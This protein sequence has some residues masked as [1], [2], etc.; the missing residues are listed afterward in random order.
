MSSPLRPGGGSTD[1]AVEIFYEALKNKAYTCYVGADT[2]LPMMYMHDAL[3]A[4]SQLM[5]AP[6]ASLSRSVYNVTAFS[7]S[8]RML[9]AIVA[10]HIP[11]FTMNCVPDFRDAIA[12]S[13][14]KSIDDSIAARDFG[15]KPEWGLEK[16]S[17]DMLEKVKA[18][19]G[20]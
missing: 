17:A 8:P 14:P 3:R 13:W 6:R 2:T 19:L 16:T 4:T 18:K 20:L 10:R 9:E 5:Q 1:W 12:S 15:W 11:G 7:V